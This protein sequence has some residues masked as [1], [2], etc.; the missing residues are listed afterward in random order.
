VTAPPSFR[1]QGPLEPDVAG[2]GGEAADLINQ[3]SGE[4][5][6]RP[7]STLGMSLAADVPVV[8]LPP[9]RRSYGGYQSN[10]PEFRSLSESLKDM[11]GLA[12]A[13]FQGKVHGASFVVDGVRGRDF[14]K[15]PTRRQEMNRRKTR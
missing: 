1:T 3:L 8:M 14:A 15:N 9:G 6:P 2:A 7:G 12:V 11:T 13:T 4:D 5:L 10:S